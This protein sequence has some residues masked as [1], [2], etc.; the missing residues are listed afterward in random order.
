MQDGA[1]MVGGVGVE[2]PKSR[3]SSWR[4]TIKRRRGTGEGGQKG[5]EGEE[6]EECR[7]R[8]PWRRLL[9]VLRKVDEMDQIRLWD[10]EY[11][12]YTGTSNESLAETLQRAQWPASFKVV[13]WFCVFPPLL[14]SRSCARGR[15][16]TTGNARE[17]AD[18]FAQQG[19]ERGLGRVP[20]RWQ[21]VPRS[22]YW[23]K[24]LSPA[25]LKR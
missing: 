11:P 24:D 19:S 8:A 2:V 21:S 22:H 23:P 3:T 18:R 20:L 25:S 7:V 15:L 13:V 14:L 4:R 5:G 16:K 6:G 10:S 1:P 12:A 17:E 9:L